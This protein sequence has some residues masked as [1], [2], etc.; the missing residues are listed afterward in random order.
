[1]G[2]TTRFERDFEEVISEMINL[3]RI[4]GLSLSAP[5][6]MDAVLRG[7]QHLNG[8]NEAAFNKLRG[9]LVLSFKMV[10]NAA[11]SLGGESATQAVSRALAEIA[12]RYDRPL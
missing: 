3:E 12:E 2:E 4:C 9:L 10:E 5:G 11:N 8:G 6:V 7:D 1:M